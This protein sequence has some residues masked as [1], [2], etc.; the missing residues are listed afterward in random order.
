MRGSDAGGG[1]GTQGAGALPVLSNGRRRWEA[2]APYAGVQ[3]IGLYA[4][5]RQSQR[6]TRFSRSLSGT[7]FLTISFVVVSQ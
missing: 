3:G 5:T 7:K 6:I 1:R 2:V 4:C